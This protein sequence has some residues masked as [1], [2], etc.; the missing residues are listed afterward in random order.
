MTQV[1][2]SSKFKAQEDYVA[3]N[4]KGGL[5]RTTLWV[6]DGMLDEIKDVGLLM[7]QG[8]WVALEDDEKPI[9]D[10]VSMARRENA[11]R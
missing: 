2:R 10:K 11:R 3:K 8:N 9:L 5:V 4:R 1:D 7:R 6:P